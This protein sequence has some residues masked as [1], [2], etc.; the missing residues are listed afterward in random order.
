MLLFCRPRPTVKLEDKLTTLQEYLDSSNAVPKS[1]T[2]L[3]RFRQMKRF[4]SIM[5]A[6]IA[7]KGPPPHFGDK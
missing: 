4:G 6:R 3:V 2:A 5:K 1:G 7:G